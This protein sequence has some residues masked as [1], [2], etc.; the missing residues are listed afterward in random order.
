[1]RARLRPSLILSAVAALAAA[2]M[3]SS[4]A[5]AAAGS[6]HDNC[7]LSHDWESWTAPGGGDYILLRVNLHDYYRIDFTPGSHVRKDPDRFL[8]NRV[9][10]SNW[11]CG[12]LDLDLTLQ[13]HSGFQ[14]PLIARSLRK[15]TPQ[16]VAALPKKD[17]P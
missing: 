13:D 14:E 15:L 6:G 4:A 11:I 1:M 5:Q 8:V 7:F 12:P 16:E 17:R 2:A 3:A 10:G 9:R